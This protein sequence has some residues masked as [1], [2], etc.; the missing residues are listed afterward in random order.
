MTNPFDDEDG[1]F[2]ALVNDE[3]Q[4]SLWPEYLAVPEGWTVAHGPAPRAACLEHIETAWTDM[5]PRT[6][7]AATEN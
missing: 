6:L 1:T 3:G 4:Y 7:V 5:R 2:L